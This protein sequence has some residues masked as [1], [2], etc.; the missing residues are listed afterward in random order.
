MA[1]RARTS[2]CTLAQARSRL[3]QAETFLMVADLVLGDDSDTKLPSP[4]WCESAW[5]WGA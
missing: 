3:R 2:Q 1:R 5:G 4:R